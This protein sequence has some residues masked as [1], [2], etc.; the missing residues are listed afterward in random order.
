MFSCSRFSPRLVS[1]SRVPGVTR[2]HHKPKRVSAVSSWR[3]EHPRGLIP[4]DFISRWPVR[5]SKCHRYSVPQASM[6]PLPP[7]RFPVL[8]LSR[9]GWGN[10]DCWE[11]WGNRRSCGLICRLDGWLCSGYGDELPVLQLES[12]SIQLAGMRGWRNSCHFLRLKR[13]KL[14]V[15]LVGFP[16]DNTTS[17]RSTVVKG[18]HDS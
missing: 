16:Y 18:R 4:S 2:S 3:K 11:R 1:Y 9:A 13:Q 8:D 15:V 12:E 5:E 6:P 14:F 10:G 7:A 17:L